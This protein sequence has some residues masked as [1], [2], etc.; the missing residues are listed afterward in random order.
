MANEQM[1]KG[2][3]GTSEFTGFGYG[4]AGTQEAGVIA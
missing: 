2:S 4:R 1:V 3:A